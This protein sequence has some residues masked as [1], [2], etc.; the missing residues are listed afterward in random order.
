M[1]AESFP[2]AI[3][4]KGVTGHVVSNRSSYA[5]ELIEVRDAGIVILARNTFRF[6]PYSTIKSSGFD[7]IGASISGRKAPSSKARE[8]L[9]LVSRF[10]QGLT[11]ELLQKLLSAN[12][13]AALA[14]ENP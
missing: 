14:Q 13:Q 2:P 12:K 9:R 10:P 6:V 5:V 4:P 3:T 7:G 8:R 1:T 11:P